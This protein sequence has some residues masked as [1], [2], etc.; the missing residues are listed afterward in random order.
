MLA[1]MQ[2]TINF[3][4]WWRYISGGKVVQNANL[5]TEIAPPGGEI[6]KK[7]RRKCTGNFPLYQTQNKFCSYL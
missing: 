2:Q 3:A 4:S 6:E 7:E 1:S 5:T